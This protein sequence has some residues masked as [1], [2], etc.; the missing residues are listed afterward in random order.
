QIAQVAARFWDAEQ[1][2]GV[3][4]LEAHAHPR[5]LC[6]RTNEFT[7]PRRLQ[8][9]ERALSLPP[10][11]VGCNEGILLMASMVTGRSLSPKRKEIAGSRSGRGSAP[12]TQA[13]IR[14]RPPSRTPRP[15]PPGP[16]PSARPGCRSA[17]RTPLRRTSSPPGPPAPYRSRTAGTNG[18][19]G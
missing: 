16:L 19:V 10:P 7:R 12:P 3:R 4:V 11:R 18:T 15:L 1:D 6:G 2:G 5:A 14:S 13:G 8:D 17:G 9:I